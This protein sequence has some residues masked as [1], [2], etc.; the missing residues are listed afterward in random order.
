MPARLP[1]FALA[2]LATLVASGFALPLDGR[3]SDDDPRAAP[4]ESGHV[5]W[6]ATKGAPESSGEQSR[7][8][9]PS[10]DRPARV[11]PSNV[12]RLVSGVAPAGGHELHRTPFHLR[13]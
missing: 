8:D 12:G 10:L 9:L 7:S 11:G 6:A 5:A 2:I 4:L 3:G 13:L 1:T